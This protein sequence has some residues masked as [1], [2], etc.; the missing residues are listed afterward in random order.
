MN[1]DYSRVRGRDAR[2]NVK[3]YIRKSDYRH[4]KHAISRP[5]IADVSLVLHADARHADG[6]GQMGLAGARLADQ[7][8][9]VLV[10]GEG[11]AG[12]HW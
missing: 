8:D 10:V 7:H 12:Q 3:R 11:G 4:E 1:G 6:W 9:V 5:C 2:F